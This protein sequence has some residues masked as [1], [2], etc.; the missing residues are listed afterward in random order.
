[1][2]MT[3]KLHKANTLD[4]TVMDAKTVLRMATIYGAR[5]IG[6]GD[7]IGSLEPGKQADLI[8]IDTNKPHLT[9]LYHPASHIVYT[10][11][12]ADVRDVM[13]AG[14]F[15]VKDYRLLS[16]DAGAVIKEVS[17]LAGII[18]KQA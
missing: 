15:L 8:I 4:P 11:S 3:A 5:A 2:D 18:K 10:V 17:D 7:A 13:V 12:G 6:L 1:M 16:L 9:P 14:K